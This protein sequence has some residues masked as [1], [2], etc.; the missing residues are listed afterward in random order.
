MNYRFKNIGDI[1]KELKKQ[2]HL[3]EKYSGNISSKINKISSDNEDV[4]KTLKIE[5][6]I[7]DITSLKA[8]LLSNNRHQAMHSFMQIVQFVIDE[9]ENNNITNKTLKKD[10]LLF[11]KIADLSYRFETFC[12]DDKKQFLL[13]E[14]I[15]N[16]LRNLVGILLGDKYIGFNQMTVPAFHITFDFKTRDR[17]KITDKDFIKNFIITT[18]KTLGMSILHG[19]NLMEGAPE[20]PGITGF[21]V[22]DFSHIAIHTFVLPHGLENEVFMDIFSCKPYDREKVVES[23]EKTFNVEKHRV[24]YEVLSFGE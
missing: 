2:L 24:N 9:I 7:I 23:I 8:K 3:L 15:R 18:I 4:K 17:D 12:K 10:Q 20:N 19:P 5:S 13:F 6:E 22:I 11:N 16:L 21:A 1:N 14:N